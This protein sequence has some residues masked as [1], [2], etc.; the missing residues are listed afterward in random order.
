MIHSKS[1]VFLGAALAVVMFSSEADAH[2]GNDLWGSAYN[3]VVRPESDTVTVPPRGSGE[4]E[5][6]CSEQHGLRLGRVQP[7][8]GY[9][10]QVRDGESRVA[11]GERQADAWGEAE[12]HP[13]SYEER[14]R[15]CQRDGYQLFCELRLRRGQHVRAKRV[16]ERKGRHDQED[17]WHAFPDSTAARPGQGILHDAGH[18]AALCRLFGLW[19]HRYW[20][21]Q[22]AQALLCWPRIMEH[23]QRCCDQEQLPRYDHHDREL[24]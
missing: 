20:S 9:R 11:G 23:W 22:L 8:G 4:P 13:D 3:L 6:V 12:V 21:R 16:G 19:R 15:I 18:A 17:R 2:W 14:R 24:S 5:C 10:W 1:R 7:R